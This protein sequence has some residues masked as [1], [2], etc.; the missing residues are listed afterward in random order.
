MARP[1]YL[2]R[3]TSYR[4]AESAGQPISTSQ[5][6]AEFN[7]GYEVTNQ[8]NRLMRGIT[9]ATGKLINISAQLAQSLVGSTRF[10][11]IIATTVFLTTVEWDAS[12]SSG[13][14]QV[15]VSGVILDTTTYSV[16]DNGGFLEVTVSVPISSGWVYV[17]AYSQGAGIATMLASTDPGNGAS[18]V[19]INDVDALYVSTNVEGA[20][21]EI[22][23]AF[24]TL[25]ASLGTINKIWTNDGVTVAG[26]PAA[27]HFQ[28]GNKRV[29]DMADAIN[30]QDAVTMQQLQSVTQNLSTLLAQFIRADG[31]VP[32]TGNQSLAGFKI[33]D[34]ALPTLPTDLA[35]KAYVDAVPSLA[36]GTVVDFAGAVAPSVAWLM[37]DG[38]AYLT[39]AYPVLSALLSASY[40]AGPTQGC[41][42]AFFAEVDSSDLTAGVLTSLPA[43]VQGVGYSAVPHIDVIN[44]DGGAAVV[45]QPTW[46]ASASGTVLT[47]AVVTGGILSVAILTG[48]VGI[49]AG[50]LIRVFNIT[51]ATFGGLNLPAL[52]TLPVGY[53]RTPDF[54][55]RSSVGPGLL[56]K[57]AGII[58][59]PARGKGDGYAGTSITV[60]SFG[61]EQKTIGEHSHLLIAPTSSP[62]PGGG[63]NITA[64]QYVPA[65]GSGSNDEAYNIPGVATPASVG[66]SSVTGDSITLPPY[67]SL[68]KIIKAL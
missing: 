60:D 31:S 25:L 12:F 64:E 41:V 49:R 36:I 11:P 24:N 8:L 14:V 48:G 16:A 47:G 58:D 67:L 30:A 50:A 15:I 4:Q 46:T 52:V 54:R 19:G 39:A 27:N 3:H 62:A 32:W 51:E 2:L 43:F 68:N 66:L 28:M 53:F 7:D 33:T 59:P 23:M 13:N 56:S 61:G 44:T 63:I 9:D 22:A 40:K 37:C 6:D 38:L 65:W 18:Q 34:A 45:T 5:L 35:S 26:G 42:A 10:T 17:S 29:I 21:A 1:P 55:G 20:L 57:T